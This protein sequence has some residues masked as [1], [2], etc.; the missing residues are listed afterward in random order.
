MGE[1]LIG[2]ARVMAWLF[3]SMATSGVPGLLIVLGPPVLALAT[4]VAVGRGEA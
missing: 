1:D 2:A 4:V 3:W